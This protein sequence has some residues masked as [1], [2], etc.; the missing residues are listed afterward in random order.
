ML[1]PTPE[2]GTHPLFEHLAPRGCAYGMSA[3]GAEASLAGAPPGTHVVRLEREQCYVSV[4]AQNRGVMHVPV[5]R[6]G[7]HVTEA[8]V[9]ASLAHVRGPLGERRQDSASALLGP[10]TKY[11]ALTH[12]LVGAQEPHASSLARLAVAFLHDLACDRGPLHGELLEVAAS[13]TPLYERLLTLGLEMGHCGRLFEKAVRQLMLDNVGRP[14]WLAAYDA[15]N[16]ALADVTLRGVREPVLR[17]LLGYMP[18]PS[19]ALHQAPD[20]P[21]SLAVTYAHGGGVSTEP[22]VLDVEGSYR[23]SDLGPFATVRELARG[24]E[25][26]GYTLV[27]PV[28]HDDRPPQ[29]AP[30]VEF[31]AE[32]V[33]KVL[34]DSRPS[35]LRTPDGR[36]ITMGRTVDMGGSGKVRLGLGPDGNPVAIKEYS[37]EFHKTS[38]NPPRKG[39]RPYRTPLAGVTEEVARTAAI[40]NDLRVTDAFYVNGRVYTIMPLMEGNTHALK[41]R[42][43]PEE[44]RLLGRAMLG[45]GADDLA[46]MAQRGWVHLDL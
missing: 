42:C 41:G 16:A 40:S 44:R 37:T 18:P 13:L 26:R 24:I 3:A 20:D 6:R 4:V 31:G 8:D 25:E 33:A 19:A 27:E 15:W 12:L 45:Q 38:L 29:P 5:P 35:E 11:L 46:A 30:T 2:A 7:G 14:A 1:D 10:A 36:T 9:L 32:K 39:K 21:L 28:V 34:N 22:V 23:V 17:T 43:T